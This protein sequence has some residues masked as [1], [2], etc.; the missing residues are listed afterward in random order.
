MCFIIFSKNAEE[1]FTV[2]RWQISTAY[3][4]LNPLLSW[5]IDFKTIWVLIFISYSHFNCYCLFVMFVCLIFAVALLMNLRCLMK[6]TK[7]VPACLLC[8][9]E[10][11]WK[12]EILM[13]KV[14]SSWNIWK[15]T[16][17]EQDSVEESGVGWN[18]EITNHKFTK[19][20]KVF[21]F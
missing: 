9:T 10:C 21:Y 5:L 19:V 11:F 17:L 20:L 12:Q 3:V 6:K 7:K 4:Q 1:S 16:V 8:F 14:R 2:K 13:K 18:L 15:F